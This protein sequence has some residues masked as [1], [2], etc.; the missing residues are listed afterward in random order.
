MDFFTEESAQRII[1]DIKEH[2]YVLSK[3]S[4][5][6]FV[7]EFNY[8]V[9]A[10]QA[11]NKFDNLGYGCELYKESES[12]FWSLAVRADLIGDVNYIIDTE[13]IINEI[14]K[15]FKGIY[16]EWYVVYAPGYRKVGE[17]RK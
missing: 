10:K 6:Y 1:N 5:I 4:A 7:F 11:K 17:A 14:V 3:E 12:V 16:S 15:E 9:Y 2:E 8:K 13:K